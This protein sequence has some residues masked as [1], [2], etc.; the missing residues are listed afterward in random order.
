MTRGKLDT[1]VLWVTISLLAIPQKLGE[2]IS[3][4]P[5]ENGN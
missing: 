5:K 2:Q 1:A 4:E 3:A